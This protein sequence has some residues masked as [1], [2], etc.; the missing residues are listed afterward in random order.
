MELLG[1]TSWLEALSSSTTLDLSSKQAWS[2]LQS[3]MY[4]SKDE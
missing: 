1:E 3:S 4:I 2:Q